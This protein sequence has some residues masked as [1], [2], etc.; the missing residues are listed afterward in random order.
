M[1]CILLILG[2]F[3]FP[4]ITLAQNVLYT[5]HITE[6]PIESQAETAV[7]SK[8][9]FITSNSILLFYG[10]KLYYISNLPQY[11]DRDSIELSSQIQVIDTDLVVP[12]V[13][14]NEP[15]PLRFNHSILYLTQNGN[16]YNL[17]SINMDNLAIQV[18]HQGDGGN[19]LEAR[20]NDFQIIVQMENTLLDIQN[21]TDRTSY[22]VAVIDDDVLFHN[23]IPGLNRLF[24]LKQNDSTN[25]LMEYNLINKNEATMLSDVEYFLVYPRQAKMFIARTSDNHDN[26]DIYKMHLISRQFD[27]VC[28]NVI[29]REIL[30]S[31]IP[32]SDF[33]MKMAFEY[34]V[35]LPGFFFMRENQQQNDLY[36]MNEATGEETLIYENILDFRVF[37]NVNQLIIFAPGEMQGEIKVLKAEFTNPSQ[38]SEIAS[39]IYFSDSTFGYA[40]ERDILYFVEKSGQNWK[41]QLINLETLN[42]RFEYDFTNTE[43]DT[44]QISSYNLQ[45]L[46]IINASTKGLFYH[47]TRDQTASFNGKIVG[48]NLDDEFAIVLENGNTLQ[49]YYVGPTELQEQVEEVQVVT[50]IEQQQETEVVSE[51]EPW[52]IP[53]GIGIKTGVTLCSLFV[54]TAVIGA[55]GGAIPY[56]SFEFFD[57]LTLEAGLGFITKR[58]D[59]PMDKNPEDLR[60]DGYINS[61]TLAI[62]IL[63][64]GGYPL[65]PFKFF[66]AVGIEPVIHMHNEAKTFAPTL[67]NWNS[68]VDI[69]N[70]DI[71]AGLSVYF[72]LTQYFFKDLFDIDYEADIFLDFFF[73]V[74]AMQYIAS[75][76]DIFAGPSNL[77]GFE[78]M[79][80][81][82]AY[83]F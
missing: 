50:I 42:N 71:L 82:T 12:E 11:Q 32:Y 24:Y 72:D 76:Q 15:V 70:L 80:G 43:P 46:F 51:D 19:Y 83:K 44:I 3:L 34:A 25:D 23:I 16:R 57:Y 37:N 5:K 7:Y 2:L 55:G 66:G 52:E 9:F 48:L 21:S 78:I 41:T 67:Q 65:Y 45:K 1:Y 13:G 73:K 14:L 60:T 49:L 36:L 33:F 26:L 47:V 69:F 35:I 18:I 39:Q 31:P 77:W 22:E 29:P 20:E 38:S 10:D 62:P 58:I 64:K 40:S 61:Y 68:F 28:N 56:V 4:Q 54:D 81:I 8:A 30:H 17:K 74:G 53:I 59:F 27:F 6:I 75:E 63:L 79:L